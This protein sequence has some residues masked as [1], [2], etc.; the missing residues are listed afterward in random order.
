ML[1]ID[2]LDHEV[3]RDLGRPPPRSAPAHSS[4]VTF[5]DLL[6]ATFNATIETFL[7]LIRGFIDKSLQF[8]L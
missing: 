6:P 2:I 1:L 4:N 3:G 5:F 7:Q 8:E